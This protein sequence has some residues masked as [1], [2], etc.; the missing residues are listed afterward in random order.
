MCSGDH[1]TGLEALDAESAAAHLALADALTSPTAPLAPGGLAILQPLLGALTT[2]TQRQ[3]TARDAIIADLLDL[4]HKKDDELHDHRRQRFGQKSERATEEDGQAAGGETAQGAID[5]SAGGDRNDADGKADGRDGG[6]E[7]DGDADGEDASTDSSSDTTHQ[8]DTDESAGKPGPKKPRNPRRDLAEKREAD[9]VLH[10]EPESLICAACGGKLRIKDYDP[11]LRKCIVEAH[12]KFIE[13]RYAITSC[14]GC[15]RVEQVPRAPNLFAGS[16]Y[17]ASVFAAIA[18]QKFAAS[19]SLYTLDKV[20]FA[21]YNGLTRSYMSR[22]LTDGADNIADLWAAIGDYVLSQDYISMDETTLPVLGVVK[23]KAHR[24]YGFGIM[25]GGT[26]ALGAPDA[27][28]FFN[29]SNVRTGKFAEEMLKGFNG[30][31]TVDKFSGYLRFCNVRTQKGLRVRIMFCHAHARRNFEKIAKK[32]KSPI[33]RQMIK[34][35]KLIYAI[36]KEIRGASP[37]ERS[38]VRRAKALPILREIRAYLLTQ[39][40]RLPQT[41]KLADAVA[42]ILDHFREFRRYCM[43]GSANID[44]NPL[45]RG[46]RRWT[47]TRRS[48]LFAGSLKGARAWSILSSV[49]ET[50]KLHDVDP[51]RYLTWYCRKKAAGGDAFIPKHHFPWHFKAHP[52]YETFKTS[53]LPRSTMLKSQRAASALPQV[54]AA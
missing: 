38:R 41:G 7:D 13:E 16:S 8:S 46:I 17:D 53:E 18:V 5:K 3:I 22:I 10:H 31:C 36:E 47:V 44:N 27:A 25:A 35:Y 48:S 40:E 26:T 51:F 9:E 19:T 50:C 37:E 20:I 30:A 43:I 14:E 1:R 2:A 32:N 15:E 42:Y 49:I 6:T 29:Y 45:E 39:R 21:N 4:I 23:G 34:Y 52:D 24:G 11:T 28:V 12:I 33:A 54:I